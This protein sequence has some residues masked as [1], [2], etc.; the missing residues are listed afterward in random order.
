MDEVDRFLNAPNFYAA[1]GLNR[2]TLTNEQV[3]KAYKKYALKFH[4]DKNKNKNAT[5]A[6]MKLGEIR[7]T[8]KNPSKRNIYDN[9]TFPSETQRAHTV[10]SSNYSAHQSK[11][12]DTTEE[13]T[14][15]KVK[16]TQ[17]NRKSLVKI[18]CIIFLLLG[19]ACFID[20]TEP[21]SNSITK[22]SL[23]KIIKFSFDNDNP[24]DF[25]QYYSK[26]LLIPFY[27][28]KKW[29][30]ENILLSDDTSDWYSLREQIRAYADDLYIEKLQTECEKEKRSSSTTSHPSCIRLENI[31]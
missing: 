23:S 18:I 24:F 9:I 26:T 5:Q 15:Q 28:P 14:P 6:F 22:E 31:I 12:N 27:I 4:P 1:L 30:K 25:T 17:K 21:F 8:L 20:E 16:P 7:E 13:P 3:D 19:I 11:W 10:P 2:N 29:E